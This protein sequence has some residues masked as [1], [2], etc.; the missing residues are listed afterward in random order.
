MSLRQRLPRHERT[1]HGAIRLRWR[2]RTPAMGAG[3][4]DHVWTFRELLTAQFE[5][6]NSEGLADEHPR[7]QTANS[8]DSTC[9]ALTGRGQIPR[10]HTAALCEERSMVQTHF[11]QSET[12]RW[13]C[14]EHGHGRE[15]LVLVMGI[16]PQDESGASPRQ[17]WMRPISYHCH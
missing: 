3:L 11:I 5:P 15:T 12:T 7:L 4:T 10:P 8:S 2:E 13:Q 16:K 9:Y 6:F 1:R 14:F 17:P